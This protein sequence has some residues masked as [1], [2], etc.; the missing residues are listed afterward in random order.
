MRQRVYSYDGYRVEMDGMFKGVYDV[1]RLI[2]LDVIDGLS[3][4]MEVYYMDGSNLSIDYIED[5][6]KRKVEYQISVTESI[7]LYGSNI[8]ISKRLTVHYDVF[9]ESKHRNI[10]IK[11]YDKKLKPHITLDSYI[12]DVNELS[13]HHI[14]SY[15]GLYEMYLDEPMY[16]NYRRM[17]SLD[18]RGRLDVKELVVNDIHITGRVYDELDKIL[19]EQTKIEINNI[20]IDDT[21]YLISENDQV[22]INTD[23]LYSGGNVVVGNRRD[24]TDNVLTLKSYV[25]DSSFMYM[26]NG[27]DEMFKM[28]VEGDK[29]K[30]Y[31]GDKQ[32]LEIVYREDRDSFLY[33]FNGLIDYSTISE[34]HSLDVGDIHIYSNKIVNEGIDNNIISFEKSGNEVFNIGAHDVR[35]HKKLIGYGG[36]DV[37]N[38][39]NQLSDRRVKRDISRIENALDKID[40][41]TGIT[42]ENI[43]KSNDRGR[44]C[45]LIAQDVND[46][47]PEAVIENTDGY[48]YVQYGNMIGLIVEGM[49]ELREEIKKLK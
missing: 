2:K 24:D 40:R 23:M 34:N 39:I 10:D 14:Y 29:F 48:M 9:D 13:K 27:V 25:N 42:Y 47:L 28:G 7:D 44:E 31:K 45:G 1:S 46:V 30:I 32:A 38:G 37:Y 26:E 15:D 33:R 22:L 19:R 16:G 36:I 35:C 20:I 6:R 11:V 3:C 21:V 4:N 41:L 8:D 5:D 17:L 49:K 18:R 12:D 43:L